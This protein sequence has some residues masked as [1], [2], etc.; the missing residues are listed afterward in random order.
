MFA[1]FVAEAQLVVSNAPPYNTPQNLVQNVLLGTGVTAS[2][3][4]YM[5]AA[6][7]IGFFDGQNSNL[8]LD[9]G[10]V[11]CSGDIINAV[12]PNNIGSQSTAANTPGNPLLDNLIPG[13]TTNDAAVLQFDFV[14]SADTIKFNYVFG[15]EEY[16]E[17][18]NSSFNDVFGFF[19]SGPNP[20]GGFYNQ[21]NIAQIPG[22]TMPVTIDNVN[23]FVNSQY[24]VDNENPPGQTVQYDGFTTVLTAIL[25]VECNETYTI[26]IGVADAGDSAYDSGVFLQAS[27]FSSSGPSV[28]SGSQSQFTFNDTT[29]I[30][31]CDDAQL[32][33]SLPAPSPTDTALYLVYSGT[34]T[35]GVDYMNL[36][37]SVMISAG[38]TAVVLTIE[39]FIDTEIEGDEIIEVTIPISSPCSSVTEVGIEFLIIDVEPLSVNP[40]SDTLICPGSDVFLDIEA[41]GGF[42]F[43]DTT[44]TLVSSLSYTWSNGDTTTSTQV[45]PQTPTTYYYT[46]YDA[47]AIQTYL[48]SVFVD[49]AQI[50]PVD[51]EI[52]QVE[53]MLCVGPASNQTIL[54]DTTGGLYNNIVWQTDG[55]PGTF[56]DLTGET[57][58]GP[59]EGGL[60][61]IVV[62]ATDFCGNTDIVTV[63]VE[64]IDCELPNVFSP[65]GDGT[66]D[67]FYISKATTAKN[68]TLHIYNRWGTLVYKNE[69]YQNC[70]SPNSSNCWDGKNSFTGGDC[71]EGVYYFTL[72]FDDDR[73]PDKGHVTLFR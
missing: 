22:T 23:N 2:N 67:F 57:N 43:Y 4:Q 9:S 25:P 42:E 58:L 53:E 51:I 21:Q 45:A 44:G 65:Q 72:T 56:N 7:G 36:P 48:D 14:P 37:D 16:M 59:S 34:A 27:S 33:I 71:A 12:G 35:M 1:T 8:G 54:T 11:L 68:A 28:S 46:V 62:T 64:V 5:G 55:M 18:V 69:S 73:N 61:E 3:F 41:T 38:D 70:N 40:I 47:C 26:T 32:Y 6:S 19:V 30:E 63:D 24:Y 39:A 10:L 66:H 52:I 60:Y 29:L 50:A 31:G 20:A 13:F 49:I 17:W 15:S